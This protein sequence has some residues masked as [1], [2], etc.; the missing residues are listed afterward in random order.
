MSEVEAIK[1]VLPRRVIQA[2][3]LA[4]QRRHKTE[5]EIV[6]EAVQSYLE[7]AAT[8]DPLFGLFADEPE[9]IDHVTDEAM[10]QREMMRLRMTP[11]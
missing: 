5:S 1:L 6:V 11:G 3:E 8:I 9:L 7:R 2:L 4:A 10:R